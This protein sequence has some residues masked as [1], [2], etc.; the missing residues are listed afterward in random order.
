MNAKAKTEA[1]YK[2]TRTVITHG[3][4]VIT[5]EHDNDDDATT[6]TRDFANG[7]FTIDDL[8]GSALP[9]GDGDPVVTFTDLPNI[10]DN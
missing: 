5:V 7:D 2:R 3:T 1:G 10:D 8:I 9:Y 4:T 6:M